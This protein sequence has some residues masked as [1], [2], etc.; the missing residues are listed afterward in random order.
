M[1]F[2]EV[3]PAEARTIGV[4]MAGRNYTPDCQRPHFTSWPISSANRS[5]RTLD[6]VVQAE[7]W[8]TFTPFLQARLSSG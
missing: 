2:V 7:R 6:P 5:S 4:E 3:D 8:K 1:L